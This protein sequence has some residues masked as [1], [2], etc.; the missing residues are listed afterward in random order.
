M[1][2]PKSAIRVLFC[3]VCM[4]NDQIGQSDQVKNAK[5]RQT[6]SALVRVAIHT[7]QLCEGEPWPIRETRY[8]KF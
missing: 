3:L 1:S 5:K 7:I 2:P 6:S 8:R 4:A